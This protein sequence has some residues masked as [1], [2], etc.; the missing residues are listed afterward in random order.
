MINR[1]IEPAEGAILINGENVLKMDPI[2]LRRNIV[3]YCIS[4]AGHPFIYELSR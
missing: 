4:V 1:L 2:E 3:L